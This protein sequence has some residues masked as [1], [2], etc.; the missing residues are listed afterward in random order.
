MTFIQP[1]WLFSG[2]K[3]TRLQEQAPCTT[4]GWFPCKGTTEPLGQ[5]THS[6]RWP[7]QLHRHD[8]ATAVTAAV[9]GEGKEVSH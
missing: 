7:F 3:A 5:E 2:G 4:H 8:Q 9:W 6:A 1:H